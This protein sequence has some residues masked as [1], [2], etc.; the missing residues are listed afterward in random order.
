MI[1]VGLERG[2]RNEAVIVVVVSMVGD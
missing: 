1:A 2:K